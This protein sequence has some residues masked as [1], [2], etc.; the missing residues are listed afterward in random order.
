MHIIYI[1]TKLELGGAQKVCLALHNGLKLQDV[2]TSLISGSD[3]VLVSSVADDKSVILLPS[4]TRELSLSGIFN[5]IKAFWEL[6][7]TIKQLSAQSKKQTVVHTH[8]TKAGILGRWAALF[9]GIQARVHTVHGFAFHE[10]QSWLTWIIIFTCELIT[11]L[12]TTHFVVVS[13]YDQQIGSR[14]LPFFK[15]NNTIIRASAFTRPQEPLKKNTEPFSIENP[16]IIGTVSCFKPQKNLK[17]LILIFSDLIN[18]HHITARLEIIGDGEQ[19]ASLENLAKEKGVFHLM[20]FA[21][22]QKDISPWL[23]RWNIFALTSL[24][25]GLPCAVVEARLF[26]IPVIC[27][28]TGGIKDV[29]KDGENGFLINQLDT[30]TFTQKLSLISQNHDL[31]QKMSTHF[32]DLEEFQINFMVNKHLEL[33]TKLLS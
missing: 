8:S 5:E 17:D 1:I 11:S 10:Y 19:R 9:A 21:G 6:I 20:T 24:W 23:Y 16:L 26:Q 29:I 27:Y 4:I 13:S 25:E 22:W 33:Y 3:G 18:H 2:E 31:Y 12:I 7:K 28:N 15:N 30:K 14:L 32:D